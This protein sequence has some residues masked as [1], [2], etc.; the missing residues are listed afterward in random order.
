MFNRAIHSAVLA[1]V[2]MSMVAGMTG[3]NGPTKAGEQ[4][5]SQANDRM[6]II[7]AQVHYDQAKQAFQT[8]QFD[9]AQR[10]IR[11]AIARYGD[12]PNYYVLQGRIFLETHQLEAALDTFRT[13]IEMCEKQIAL[14]EEAVAGNAPTQIIAPS[15]SSSSFVTAT[16][17]TL[18]LADAYYFTGIVFQRWSDDER[19]HQNY[20]AAF[21]LQPTNAQYLL[22]AAESLI[23]LGDFT[24]A[25]DLITPKMAYFEH[26]AALRQLQA[27]IAMLQGNPE[28]AAALYAEARLLNPDDI[29]LLEQLMWAQYAAGQYGPCHESIKRIQ[30]QLDVRA[31][32]GLASSES[33]RSTSASR[34]DLLH[35][36]ARTLNMMGRTTEAR[37]L[38]IQLSTLNPSDPS[39]WAELGTLA[40]ELGDYRRVAMCSVQLI[41]LTPNRYEGYML[42]GINER[43]KN[44]L[45]EAIRL[46]RQAAERAPDTALPHLLLGQS[47]EQA[48]D[49]NNAALAY[50]MARQVEPN[51]AEA[52][53][54]FRRLSEQQHVATGALPTPMD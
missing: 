46:F 9:K 2:S 50:D 45:N 18:V 21:N 39:V 43:S 11:R 28:R 15:K 33:G 19:A 31:S 41:A 27:Q 42:R 7:N 4:A 25:S 8:G 10:E 49:V 14:A 12:S 47:L 44:N 34:T 5:R 16:G 38:Y 40:W 20:A 3:C 26:N 13:A 32:R 23:A 52:N 35:L 54:L 17:E 1:V 51:S 6:N 48:G 22:A 53:A 29:A 37:E 30:N 36:E 24:G